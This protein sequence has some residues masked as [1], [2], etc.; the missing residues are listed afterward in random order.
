MAS[1]IFYFTPAA[2]CLFVHLK[3]MV[4]Y[5]LWSMKEKATRSKS[6][7]RH[8]EVESPTRRSC[9]TKYGLILEA[10]EVTAKNFVWPFNKL[11]KVT[12]LLSASTHEL[13]DMNGRT[14]ALLNEQALKPYLSQNS[15]T[16]RRKIVS[17]VKSSHSFWKGEI[18]VGSTVWQCGLLTTSIIMPSKSEHHKY[19]SSHLSWLTYFR[20]K[21]QFTK[22]NS[23][24]FQSPHFKLFGVQHL[25]HC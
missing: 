11:W 4:Y 5:E 12:K 7:Y 18:T 17:E 25:P 9:V 22:V 2:F 1:I 3:I 20:M 19:L 24:F 10:V 23:I 16:D 14:R 15:G 21:P 13:A 8:Q 6:Q